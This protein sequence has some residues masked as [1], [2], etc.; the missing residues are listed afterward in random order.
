VTDQPQPLPPSDV[1][2]QL[3][4]PDEDL[5][6][7][8]A[9]L[10]DELPVGIILYDVRDDFRIS[11]ANPVMEDWAA[12]ETRP[13]LGRTLREM[14]PG[15]SVDGI[16]RALDDIA[17]SGAAQ[18]WRNFR[19]RRP[20][21]GGGPDQYSYWD[22]NAIPLKTPAGHVTH[23]MAVA[24]NETTQE[25]V[26]ERLQISLDLA[27]DLTS[28]L[29]A[30]EVVDR[31]LERA[32]TALR[33]DRANLLR[34]EGE[35]VEVAGAIDLSGAAPERGR[36]WAITS[37]QFQEMIR[38]RRPLTERFD[39]EGLP[40]DVQ[41]EVHDVRH[42]ATVPLVVE[43]QVFAALTV[44]RRK[45]E[46]FTTGDMLTIQQIGS[47]SVLAVRNA[48][49]F[50]EVQ[51][52]QQQ[53]ERLAE[54]LR[55]GVELALDLAEQPSPSAVIRQ[56]LRR[57]MDSLGA[58]R[59]TL[60]SVA[61]H[62]ILIEDSL[63]PGEAPRLRVGS[64]WPISEQPL[65]AAAIAARQPTRGARDNPDLPVASTD[66]WDLE[67]VVMVPL[68]L[69]GEVTAVLGASRLGPPAFNDEEIATLQQ[70]GSVAVL[71]VRNARLLEEAQDASRAKSDFLNLAAH[72]LR[73]PL[74]VISGYLSMLQDGSFGTPSDLWR[75]PVDTVAVKAAELS[76]LVRSLLTAARIQS[77]TL[78]ANRSVTDLRHLLIDARARAGPRAQM[79]GG[80][81]SLELPPKAVPVLVDDDQVGR[82]LD[83]LVNNALTYSQPPALVRV[84]LKVDD[85]AHV[86]VRDNGIGLEP[87]QAAR[88]FERFFRAEP[89][90]TMHSGTGLGLYIARQLANG[91]GGTVELVETRVG[92]G[93][94]FELRLPL[95]GE[96]G[97]ASA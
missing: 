42:S 91:H 21:V 62:H 65:V 85:A 45:D 2:R 80:E 39:V 5:P 9:R 54:R 83:N 27:L 28:S 13:L 4:H 95:V 19:F 35:E 71:A 77:G 78:P 46:P 97:E 37:P 68:V 31:L 41:S 3:V 75:A 55:I 66:L 69:Q 74:S 49:L 33:A 50:A 57:A 48:L 6:G 7:L 36:R 81:V 38:D 94:T 89:A 24:V 44:S 23:V 53:S 93:S 14:F 16:V 76:D 70:I 17:R 22:W 34:V 63:A 12:L 8:L 10:L 29:D 92:E 60:A 58:D 56:M 51:A 30:T 96:E 90:V 15:P 82:I 1:A 26:R 47:V 52:A 84:E 43:G 87:G 79:L 59:T 32:L 73:T 67:H 25:L 72:E 40:G 11:Y 86:L 64:R 88:V 18:N 61:G 20:G